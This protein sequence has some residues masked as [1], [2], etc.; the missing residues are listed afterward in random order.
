MNRGGG[1][2]CVKKGLA[3]SHKSSLDFIEKSNANL[4][5]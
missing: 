3:L 1:W 5:D 4:E 2:Q